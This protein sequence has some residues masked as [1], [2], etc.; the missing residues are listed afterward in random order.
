M[1]IEIESRVAIN[2]SSR[3]HA[4]VGLLVSKIAFIR[5]ERENEFNARLRQ[6][7]ISNPTEAELASLQAVETAMSS[8]DA[9]YKIRL[10]SLNNALKTATGQVQV[11]LDEVNLLT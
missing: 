4:V 3:L 11:I 10:S 7:K 5:S 8:L 9:A 6:R 2:A 1:S